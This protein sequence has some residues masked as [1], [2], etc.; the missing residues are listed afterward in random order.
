MANLVTP[1]IL[2]SIVFTASL[3]GSTGLAQAGNGIWTNPAGG[4]WT[5]SANWS[6]GAM[7]DGS[8]YTADF[9]TLNLI[10]TATVTLDGNRT[11]ANL[12][13]GDT[14]PSNNWFL[15]TGTGGTLTLD[16]TGTPTITVS[17]QTATVSV[18]LAG[19]K[20]LAKTGTGTLILTGSNIYTGTST[21][22]AGTLQ[23]KTPGSLPGYATPGKILLSNGATI[24]VNVGGTGEWDATALA[25]LI[26]NSAAY[27]ATSYVGID[28]TNASSGAF[29]YATAIAGVN[30]GIKKLGSG[31]LTLNAANSHSGG[32][33]VE[34]GMLK[35]G[36][37]NC[38]GALYG[39]VMVRNGATLDVAGVAA[40]SS[41][42]VVL[43][44]IGRAHV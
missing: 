12:L 42:E 32:T 26:A 28:T 40:G 37:A 33:R 7:A 10:A 44:E 17:N 20:G 3:A 21:I 1:R 30:L 14:T 4:A 29:T 19:T 6:A 36:V 16:S 5:N 18:P 31:T 39:T 11:I 41:C 22:S 8:G 13:L 15:N 24:A 9:S 2:A 34:G 38:L 35:M 25:G 43:E 27:T 23:A